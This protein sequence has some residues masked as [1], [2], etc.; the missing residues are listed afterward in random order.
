MNHVFCVKS[1]LL[2]LKFLRESFFA[3]GILI[4]SISFTRGAFIKFVLNISVA[5][6]RL[7]DLEG[8]ERS[9]TKAHA[10]APQDPLILINYAVILDAR[11]KQ[12]NAAEM[13]TALNDIMAVV[14]VDT[15]VI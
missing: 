14:D 4:E 1:S 12:A 3:D 10:L 13:L 2:I 7:D 9:L 6:K 11:G 8:A 15:Q 5:L